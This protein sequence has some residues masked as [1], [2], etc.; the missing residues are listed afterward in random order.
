[1]MEFRQ[2]LVQGLTQQMIMT[3]KM[4]QAIEMLQLCTIE[5]E[6][7]LEQQITENPLLEEV[8]SQDQE[9]GAPTSADYAPTAEMAGDAEPKNNE[10]ER[11]I[12]EEIESLMTSYDDY[13]YEGQIG[14]AHV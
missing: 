1:M 12:D 13:S 8:L 10:N 2:T 11:N 9:T 6:Y 7:Y 14:R 4:Q 5:L 3:P